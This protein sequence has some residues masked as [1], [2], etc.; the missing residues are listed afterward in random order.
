[1]RRR[2]GPRVQQAAGQ[3]QG[4][5]PAPAQP[6]QRAQPPARRPAQLHPH[7]ESRGRQRKEDAGPAA[8]PD[9]PNRLPL[10]HR[11]ATAGERRVAMAAPRGTVGRRAAMA[12]PGRRSRLFRWRRLA[13]PT[14]PQVMGS[15]RRCRAA[16]S[17]PGRSAL[18]RRWPIRAGRGAGTA[19]GRHRAGWLWGCT[20]GSNG[21]GGVSARGGL[22]SRFVFLCL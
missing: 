14:G 5:R 2:A 4:G 11:Q 12:L 1:M 13:A 18:E 15:G 20:N 22:V 7:A 21:R 9:L 3:R 6:R 16:A 8:S 17:E 19:R 10:R